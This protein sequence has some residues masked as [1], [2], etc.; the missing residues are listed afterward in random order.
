MDLSSNFYK[1][2]NFLTKDQNKKFNLFIILSVIAMI[3]EILS[4][5]LIVPLINIFVQGNINIPFLNLN[6]SL[7]TFVLIFLLTFALIFTLKNLFLVFFEKMKFKFLYELKT[8]V[9][10]KIFKNYINKIFYFT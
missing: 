8:N 10:E 1:L 5:S 4:I 9:S 6:Y 2:K 3:F 7:N